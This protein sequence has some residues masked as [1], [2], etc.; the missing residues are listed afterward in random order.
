MNYCKWWFVEVRFFEGGEV[1]QPTDLLYGQDETRVHEAEKK[2]SSRNYEH[3]VQQ[4]SQRSVYEES[5]S[6]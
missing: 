1:H 6:L 2:I 4:G 3:R 5:Q